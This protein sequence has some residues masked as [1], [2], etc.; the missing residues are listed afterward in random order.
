[1]SEEWD[2]VQSCPF[3]QCSTNRMSSE[4][5]LFSLL[6]ICCLG[7]GVGD[8]WAERTGG[9]THSLTVNS[10]GK[11]QQDSIRLHTV[12]VLTSLFNARSDWFVHLHSHI[13]LLQV[14]TRKVHGCSACVKMA[15]RFLISLPFFISSIHSLFL[16][17]YWHCEMTCDFAFGIFFSC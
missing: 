14:I 12:F 7:L 4:S 13:Q 5:D 1:M 2:A 11:L 9:R 3:S 8:A 15:L 16:C 6:E 17:L 10:P